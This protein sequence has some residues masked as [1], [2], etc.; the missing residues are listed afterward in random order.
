MADEDTTTQI[1]QEAFLNDEVVATGGTRALLDDFPSLR[2][3]Y[4]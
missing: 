4:R 2:D 1:G 3:A